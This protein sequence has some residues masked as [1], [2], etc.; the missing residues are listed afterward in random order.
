[1]TTLY[2]FQDPVAGISALEEK[3]TSF[4]LITPFVSDDPSDIV[5]YDRINGINQTCFGPPKPLTPTEMRMM[6]NYLNNDIYAKAFM[7]NNHL[8]TP[9][10]MN[11]NPVPSANGVKY[12]F[13][14]AM[15]LQKN[16]DTVYIML[17]VLNSM[18]MLFNGTMSDPVTNSGTYFYGI[19]NDFS[20]F[21]PINDTTVAN[22]TNMVLTRNCKHSIW[23]YLNA[24]GVW[25]NSQI[26]LI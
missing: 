10:D 5:V 14:T 23:A 15:A 11:G 4:A 18:N 17:G 8:F 6:N 13:N 22:R 25:I 7:D 24:R 26:N 12:S 9:L 21:Y 1:M 2:D 20:T 3:V 16:I 19:V